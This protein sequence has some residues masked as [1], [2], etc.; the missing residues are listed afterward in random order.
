MAKPKFTFLREGQRPD[1]PSWQSFMPGKDFVPGQHVL[2][3]RELPPLR[4]GGRVNLDIQ[5]T[6]AIQPALQM[7]TAQP[8]PAAPIPT[9]G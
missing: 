9:L 6:P 5:P 2:F 8:A 4:L 3:N 1:P 7:P